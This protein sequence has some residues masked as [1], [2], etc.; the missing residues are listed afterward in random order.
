CTTY[1]TGNFY[2]HH[3]DVW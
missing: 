3:F 2:I 1:Y